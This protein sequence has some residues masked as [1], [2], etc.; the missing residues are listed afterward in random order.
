MDLVFLGGIVLT[1]DGL[2]RRAEAVAV[3]GSKIR[4]V[5]PSAALVKMIGPET[6]VVHMAGRTLIPGFSDAHNHFNLTVFDPI[7]VDCRVPPHESIKGI[8]EAI[9]AA[10]SDTLRGHWIWG[11]GFDGSLVRENRNLTRRDLDEAAPDNPVCIVD[12]SVHSCY[13]NSLA[14]RLAGI[15]K[16]TPDP[17]CGQILKGSDGEPTGELWE[18]ALNSVHSQCFEGHLDHYGDQAADFVYRNCMRHLACGITSVGDALVMPRASAMYRMADEQGKLPIALRQQLGGQQFFAPPSQAAKGE[19]SSDDVSD[20]LRCGTLK[21]FMDPVFPSSA[22][23]KCHPDG[24]EEQVGARYYTQEEADQLVLAAHQRG[25]QVAIHCLGT[26]SIQQA[27]DSFERA[28]REHPRQEPRFR[29]EHFTLPTP[30]QLE[31]AKSLGVIASVQPIF[32]YT[33]ADKQQEKAR[34]LGRDWGIE[35]YKSM[36]SQGLVVAAG[37]DNPCAPL[38]PLLGIYAAVTRRCRRTGEP[39]APE[40]AVTPLEALRM[41]TINSARAL[42]RDGET[43]SIEV[44]K[45]ADLAL[46]SHDP[47]TGNP[48]FIRDIQ[49]EQTYVD[50]QLLYQHH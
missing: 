37:S 46:L 27:L 30:P 20:R 14:L 49:V 38:E 1:M 32:I 2:D 24:R 22:Q 45:R 40:E 25:M 17:H 44:G 43:G 12:I 33:W 6:R 29:I 3:E 19:I 31:R 7:S 10:A 48:D 23:I 42:L 28:S 36:I 11:S 26:W 4:A 21:M 35:A 8:Q 47:T 5:G 13:A 18:N 16:D 39:V 15:D 41:Y 9:A 50:G 34:D